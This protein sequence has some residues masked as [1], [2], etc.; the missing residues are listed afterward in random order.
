MYLLLTVSH[1]LQIKIYFCVFQPA[2]NKFN[3]LRQIAKLFFNLKC[4]NNKFNDHF[5]KWKTMHSF[6]KCVN[7][8]LYNKPGTRVVSDNMLVNVLM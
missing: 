7:I 4:K 3:I 1:I 5:R 2:N 8:C 6:E